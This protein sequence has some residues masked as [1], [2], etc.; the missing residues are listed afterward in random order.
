MS[1]SAIYLCCTRK[2]T[3]LHLIDRILNEKRSDDDILSRRSRIEGS[4]VIH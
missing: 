3:H 2:L 1:F 4:I